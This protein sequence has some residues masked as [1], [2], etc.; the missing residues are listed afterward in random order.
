MPERLSVWKRGEMAGAELVGESGAVL[1]EDATRRAKFLG[2]MDRY[3]AALRRL[4]S[5]YAERPADREDLFQEIA[6]GLWKAIPR[7]RGEASERTWLY[8]I[9]HNV[10]ISAS[11]RLWNR[12]RREEAIGEGVDYASAARDGEAEVLG[13]EKRRLLEEAIRSLGDPDRQLILLH[14][15]G[16]N[17]AQMEEVSGLSQAAIASRLSRV[18]EKL[19]ERVQ[20]AGRRRDG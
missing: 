4:V 2:L 11:V 3:E 19:R 18:R 13:A 14:L 8:R 6:V 16:L 20:A 12:G 5:G 17:Y 1:S 9:A 15:E 10:A 7:F